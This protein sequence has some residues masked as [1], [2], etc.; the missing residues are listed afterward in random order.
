[1][2]G[3]CCYCKRQFLPLLSPAMASRLGTDHTQ[4]QLPMPAFL[5]CHYANRKR[6]S[7]PLPWIQFSLC[8]S[9]ARADL[10]RSP[11]PCSILPPLCTCKGCKPAVVLLSAAS[12]RCVALCCKPAM[13][14]LHFLTSLTSL[15]V[16]P[17]PSLLDQRTSQYTTTIDFPS[18]GCSSSCSWLLLSSVT[19]FLSTL[20]PAV[21]S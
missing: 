9:A 19:S 18:S 21:S 12:Q 6:T 20:R 4:T 14:P 10:P 13:L 5:V 16:S 8:L 7:S 11:P 1:M 2:T 17:L 3:H 15:P